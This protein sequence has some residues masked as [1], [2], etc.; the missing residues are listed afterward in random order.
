MLNGEP[1]SNFK[2]G[3]RHTRVYRIWSCMLTRCNNQNEPAYAKYGARGIKV[4]DRWLVFANFLEDMGEP[5]LNESIDRIDNNFGYFKENCRWATRTV[6]N[7]NRKSCR[8]IE[9]NGIT[10]TVAEWAE[11]YGV[12]SRLIRVRLSDGWG[13]VEAVTTPLISV[14]KGIP[15]GQKL[16]EA[17]GAEKGVRFSA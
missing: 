1:M 9:I 12:K 4:C 17:F 2:H 14:R 16:R 8:F 15:R 3:K 11:V 7:R 5:N 13:E 10:K 6:Q